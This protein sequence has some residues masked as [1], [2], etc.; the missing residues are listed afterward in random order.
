MHSMMK[1]MIRNIVFDLGNVLIDYNPNRIIKAV[2]TDEESQSLFLEEIFQSKG[3]KLLDK[4]VMNFDEHTQNL[5][6]RYPQYATEIDWILKNWHK[7]QPDVQGMYSIVETLSRFEFDLYVLSNASERFIN[8]ALANNKIFQFF[9]G[10]TISAELKLLKPQKEIYDQFCKIH[11]LE[12]KECLFID[13]KAE[14]VQA[15]IDAGW[16]AYQFKGVLDLVFYLET[17]LNIKL[18]QA[19]L[20]KKEE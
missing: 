1:S 20:P 18:D 12:P 5:V 9:K 15:A 4:G 2:F 7:D 10:V 19:A 16:Q 14:N 3:W 11:N 17:T 6:S 13:D 8:F